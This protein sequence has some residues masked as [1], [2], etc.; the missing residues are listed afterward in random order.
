MDL[1]TV[2]SWIH[3]KCVK[4]LL[5]PPLK[6][7]PGPELCNRLW[8]NGNKFVSDNVLRQGSR[9]FTR[10]YIHHVMSLI[11]LKFQI[12]DLVDG[13]TWESCEIDFRKLIHKYKI[14][15]IWKEKRL[16]VVTNSKSIIIWL[17]CKLSFL[18]PLLMQ[19]VFD[20][21]LFLC[22]FHDNIY[23]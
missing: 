9:L 14:M 15:Y 21:L 18:S 16:P 22:S 4:Y 3:S 6:M 7:P 12:T 23:M 5:A 11:C 13:W 2:N 1:I 8:F 20:V 19:Y 10:T 17:F